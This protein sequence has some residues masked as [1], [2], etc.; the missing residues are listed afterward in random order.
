[1]YSQA[2]QRSLFDLSKSYLKPESDAHQ[3]AVDRKLSD[4]RKALIYHEWRYYILNDPVTGEMAG[5]EG[6]GK[7]SS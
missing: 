7:Q 1:M 3:N 5:W 2:E 6:F 4:L